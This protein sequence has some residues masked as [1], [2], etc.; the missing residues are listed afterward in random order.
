MTT[1]SP[2]APM[3]GGRV[4]ERGSR[5]VALDVERLYLDMAPKVRSY[6][7]GRLPA[8]DRDLA[9]D[10][11]GDVFVRV[12][13]HADRY[14]DRG[15]LSSW[16]YQI[17]QN[18]LVDHIRHVS[19]I[20]PPASFDPDIHDRADSTDDYDRV[21]DRMMIGDILAATTL[22]DEQRV[23]LDAFYVRGETDEMTYRR[24]GLPSNLLRKRR[25]RA[26]GALR[27]VATVLA[28]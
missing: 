18:L 23:A 21:L 19:R 22:T 8:Y 20:D 24:L 5:L 14:E 17:A 7:I 15:H 4:G 9:D 11:A 27:R 10:L 12:C 2:P 25:I 26:L 13:Q 16:V 3:P 6:F 28:A 1:M